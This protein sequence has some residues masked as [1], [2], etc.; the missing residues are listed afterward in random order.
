MKLNHLIVFLLSFVLLAGT[1]LAQQTTG[2]IRGV[3]TDSTGGVLP[4]VEVTITNQNTGR[5]VVAITVDNGTYQV[6]AITAGEYEVRVSLTG[7]KTEVGQVTVPVGT[8]M[9]A[10]FSLEI[11]LITEV[12]TVESSAIAVDTSTN[13]VQGLVTATEIA[14]LPMNGRNFLDLAQTEPGV[15]LVDGGTFDP[16][17]NQMTGISIGGRSG[18]VT[19]ITVD[20]IDLTDETV[21]TTMQNI[22]VDSVQEF[23]ISQSSLDASTGI[24][25]SGAV[26][27][28]TKA[29]GN[30]FHGSGGFY[31]RNQGMAAL[32]VAR[33]GDPETDEQIE[34]A[35]FDREQYAFD[36]GGPILA[37]KLFFFI[38]YEKVNQDGT[39]FISNSNFPFDNGPVTTPFNDNMG[40]GKLDYNINDTMQTFLRFSHETNNA[41]TG[42][43]GNLLDPFDNQNVSN[44]LVIGLD[45]AGSSLT[46]SF[47]Y[48]H[49]SFDNEIA[50]NNLGLTE[51][52][53]SNGQKIS[54][55]STNLNFRSGPSRLAPQATYQTNQTWK[56]DGGWIHG[57]HTF[58]FGSEVT[59]IK[60]N[61]FAAFFG[62]GPEVRMSFSDTNRQAIIDRGGDPQNPL[63]Y[64]FSFAV[65]GNGKG[66][67]S[68]IANQGRDLGGINNTRVAF[69]AADSWRVN[70]HLNLNFGVRWQVDTGQVNDDLPLPQELSTILGPDGVK[71]TRLD[72]DNFGPQAGFAWQ[73]GD[74]SK[75][76]VR[77]GAGIFFETQIFNNVLFDRTSR[78]PTGFGLAAFAVPFSAVDDQGRMLVLGVP[79]NQINTLLWPGQPLTAIFDE[80]AQVHRDFQFENSKLG[81]DP[82]A[83]IDILANGTDQG[84]LF[85]QD[86]D[87][88]YAVQWNIGAQHEFAPGW[89]ASADFMRNQGVHT[90]VR[91]DANRVHAANTLN[92]AGAFSRLSSFLSD[93]SYAD[94]DA[95]IA[96]GA[97]LTDIGFGSD[98]SGIDPNFARIRMI[99]TGGRSNYTA[100]QVRVQGRYDTG[101]GFLREAFGNISYSLSRFESTAVDQDFLSTTPFNDDYIGA[102]ARGP[103]GLDRLHQLSATFAL[104]FP[105]GI[106]TTI[107]HRVASDLPTII[108]V[109]DS[110][111]GNDEIF[112][113]DFDGDGTTTGISGC[114]V[115]VPGTGRGDFG[116]DVGNVEELNAVISGF[117]STLV[118]TTTPAGNALVSAGLMTQAQLIALGGVVQPL[119]L[120]PADQIMNDWLHTTDIRLSWEA[121]ITEN[122]KIEPMIEVFN[123]FNVGNWGGPANG[124]RSLTGQLNGT[125]GSI[126][127]TTAGNR[128]TRL[129]AGSGS[130]SQGLPRSAQFV[131]RIR[132]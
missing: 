54:V 126:N 95:A 76:V 52:T 102:A 32:P 106:K 111:G 63:E 30:E 96:G 124:Q 57:D 130:F 87:T 91:R 69:Y 23:Q 53:A 10:N 104:R 78:L 19:R 50:P 80:I 98:F 68:E 33:T 117:N 110:F 131:I 25:S 26:N 81:F 11:G 49:T 64:P 92:A 29:G 72:K 119:T 90:N 67:F 121:S 123:I 31:F 6:R 79:V 86:Y 35:S 39:T 60:D 112:F 15:Q 115:Y 51:F 77:G 129:G 58:R 74:S 8:I 101:A 56:Y 109:G 43:G 88:P 108:G 14:N 28:I 38:A 16:T 42:F 65:I 44:V 99:E 20:G 82:N 107:N 118:G 103:A 93:N 40:T 66:S 114:C 85:V 62:Q 34:N 73:P 22:T 5:S 27:V 24:T 37:D 9:S 47:R 7:F 89:V 21:G 4:G 48:G 12:I 3:I 100:L 2:G 127:G 45:A 97:Q 105:L 83:Q 132:F 46:H 84:G 59:W 122:V 1:P 94:L 61:V 113:T 41:A 13:T 116:R 70:S 36:V 17:K 18:R 71:P 55:R 128:S 120:A 75:T 125:G